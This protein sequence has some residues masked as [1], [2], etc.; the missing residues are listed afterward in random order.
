[1]KHPK[2]H[3]T[4]EVSR[5]MSRVRLK[6]GVAE[7]MLAKRLWHKGCRY[8]LNDRRLPGSP[9]IAI[10][11]YKLAIFVDGE[12]WHG[13]DWEARKLRLRANREYWIE[14]IE[15]NMARDRLNDQLLQA[16]GWTALH[17]WEREVKRDP[18]AC[19][20]QIFEAIVDAICR[21]GEGPLG[22]PEG[23]PAPDG[24]ADAALCPSDRPQEGT[25]GCN[26]PFDMI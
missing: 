6:R 24:D 21:S 19:V 12:F 16:R 3:T 23:A 11:R 14:K 8:R 7:T 9:D 10:G 26:D 25:L 2:F 13:Y 22:A 20:D 5:R 15:E 4:P 18:D 1:M 17:F